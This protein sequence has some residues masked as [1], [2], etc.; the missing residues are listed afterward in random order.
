MKFYSTESRTH[1]T[2]MPSI[3]RAFASVCA[4][5]TRHNLDAIY[6]DPEHRDIVATDGRVMLWGAV[7][8]ERGADEHGKGR[9]IFLPP[10][11]AA[12]LAAQKCE[13]LDIRWASPGEIVVHRTWDAVTLRLPKHSRAFP[14]NWRDK[15]SKHD[16]DAPILFDMRLIARA[17]TALSMIVDARAC[18]EVWPNGKD[19][20]LVLK[21]ETIYDD[22]RE[23]ADSEAPTTYRALVMPLAPNDADRKFDPPWV[24]RGAR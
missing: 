7:E 11:V 19:G 3:I 22:G 13:T 14:P 16:G 2:I 1:L 18:G 20:P 23:A 10:E 21:M 9:A 5:I 24:T 4:D 6:I 15:Y 8:P 12:F 17:T